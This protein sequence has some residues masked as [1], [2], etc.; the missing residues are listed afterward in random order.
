[1]ICGLHG[2]KIGSKIIPLDYMA[3]QVREVFMPN[4]T[5]PFSE[6]TGDTQVDT[7]PSSLMDSTASPKVK[8]SEG[9]GVGRA[10]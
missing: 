5:M 8:T 4:A 1:M 10:P 3:M 2:R 6:I 7:P 9:E